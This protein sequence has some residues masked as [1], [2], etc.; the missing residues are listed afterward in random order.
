MHITNVTKDYL[1]LRPH[2]LRGYLLNQSQGSEPLYDNPHDN[3][4]ISDDH[5]NYQAQSTV[6]ILHYKQMIRCYVSVIL[7]T[8]EIIIG[9]AFIFK[10][11]PS[12]TD[13]VQI[14]QP[15]KI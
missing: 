15:F 11:K 9:I 14:F 3:Y 6:I 12:I 8:K 7:L 5:D 13:M 4:H 2:R 10:C 1:Q